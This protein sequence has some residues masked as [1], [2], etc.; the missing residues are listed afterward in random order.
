MTFN[1]LPESTETSSICGIVATEEISS[2]QQFLCGPVHNS[3]WDE[4]KLFRFF[5]C[6]WCTLALCLGNTI[7][8]REPES[9]W[10]TFRSSFQLILLDILYARKQVK[11][12]IISLPIHSWALDTLHHKTQGRLVKL[13]LSWLDWIFGVTKAIEEFIELMKMRERTSTSF[14]HGF[15]C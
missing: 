11:E 6:K 13:I 9:L 15:K 10:N 7:S 1:S 8:H 4:S 2:Q 3:N 12:N 14:F 5:T